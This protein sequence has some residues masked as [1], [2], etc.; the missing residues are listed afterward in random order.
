MDSNKAAQNL[1]ELQCCHVCPTELPDMLI[2][3]TQQAITHHLEGFVSLLCVIYFLYVIFR[4][5]WFQ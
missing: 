3:M 5:H 1:G 4:G 2:F